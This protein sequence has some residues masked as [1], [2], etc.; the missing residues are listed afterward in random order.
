[1]NL[2][3]LAVNPREGWCEHTVDADPAH[4]R[5]GFSGLMGDVR[6]PTI[7]FRRPDAPPTFKQ[8]YAIAREL[9]EQVDE[10]WPQTREQASELIARLR[11][12]GG[13]S[14]PA[15]GAVA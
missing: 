9:C 5:D 12:E 10:D 4:T 6:S 2:S 7:T 11:Q 1:V 3:I 15:D 13:G 8:V 14:E